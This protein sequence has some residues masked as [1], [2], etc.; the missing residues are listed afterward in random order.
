MIGAI[1]C[2]AHRF[3]RQP[4]SLLA[5]PAQVQSQLPRAFE[6][7]TLS[8]TNDLGL[9]PQSLLSGVYTNRKAS[10]DEYEVKLQTS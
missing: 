2:L 8:H 7:N 9:H 4:T 6:R 1:G 10:I 5:A 3:G